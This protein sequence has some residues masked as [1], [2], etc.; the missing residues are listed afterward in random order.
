MPDRK[1]EKGGGDELHELSVTF[2]QTVNR[3]AGVVR[4]LESAH[5]RALQ[6]E[7]DKKRFYRDV[8][9]AVTDGKF[10]LVDRDHL[11]AEG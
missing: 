5:E 11:P 9:R 3:L 4:Q 10:E 1:P 7:I 6:A 8:I 2:R